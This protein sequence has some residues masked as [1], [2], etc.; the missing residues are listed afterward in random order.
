[1]ESHWRE[2]VGERNDEVRLCRPWKLGKLPEAPSGHCWAG[3]VDNRRDFM[4]SQSRIALPFD[5]EDPS[6][7]S[8]VWTWTMAMEVAEQAML[9]FRN[10]EILFP[11]KIVQIFN[12]GYAGAHQ[13]PAGDAA[14]GEDMRRQ[15]GFRLPREPRETRRSESL[16]DHHPVRDRKGVPHRLAGR[17][18]VLEHAGGG[19]GRHRRQALHTP[20]VAIVDR[21]SSG[22]GSSWMLCRP[23]SLPPRRHLRLQRS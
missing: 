4:T 2:A 15:M 17:N 21:S 18:A 7:R 6:A 22:R 9:A 10:D 8:V 11:G 3:T 19:H 20:L 23:A 5:S 14:G 13:L 1:M 16:C 12:S